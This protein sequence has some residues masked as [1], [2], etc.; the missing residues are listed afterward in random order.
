MNLGLT[1]ASFSL[2]ARARR[3]TA[4]APRG[5][6]PDAGRAREAHLGGQRRE[7]GLIHELRLQQDHRAGDGE[8]L[9]G[10]SSA[11]SERHRWKCDGRLS[12]RAIAVGRW[13]APP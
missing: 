2:R 13:P 5:A 9:C 10:K 7:L 6:A 8:R 12:N 11:P 4:R 3:S 1:V